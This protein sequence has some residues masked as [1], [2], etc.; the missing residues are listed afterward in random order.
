MSAAVPTLIGERCTLRELRPAD[1]AS[2]ARHGDDEAVWRNLFEGFPR[3]YTLNDALAWCGGGW[4]AGGWV[5]GV[6]ADAEVVGCIGLRPDA[7]WLRC[8]AEVGYWIGRAHWRRGLASEA[9]KLCTAWAFAAQPELTRL[10]APV[11]AWNEGSQ[12]VAR[13][14]A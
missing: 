4:R 9:L 10:Y 1:A 2:V 5:W 6:E 7:G 14:C 12:A 11:F 8:N 3:P 13:R